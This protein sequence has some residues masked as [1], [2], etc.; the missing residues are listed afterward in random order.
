MN[1]WSSG[2]WIK[3]SYILCLIYVYKAEKIILTDTVYNLRYRLVLSFSSL[4]VRGKPTEKKEP[5]N[6]NPT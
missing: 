4:T 1:L 2:L 6:H 5:D 3:T